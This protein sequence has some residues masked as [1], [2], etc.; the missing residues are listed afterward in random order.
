MAAY[1]LMLPLA[2]LLLLLLL[3]PLL[4]S[5]LALELV[6]AWAEGATRLRGSLLLPL[7]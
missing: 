2:P 1:L 5:A 7:Q 6:V 3:P 4:S